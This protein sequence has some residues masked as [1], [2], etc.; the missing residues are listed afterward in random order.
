MPRSVSST[1]TRTRSSKSSRSP[2][3]HWL[4]PTLVASVYGMNLRFPELLLLGDLAYP[5]TVGLMI[6]TAVVPMLYF[7]KRGWLR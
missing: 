4:P 1:S 5:Y 3:W 2:A 7:Y 6:A